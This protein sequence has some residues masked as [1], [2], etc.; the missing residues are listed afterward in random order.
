[1]KFIYFTTFFCIATLFAITNW[2]M[3][4][5]AQSIQV[6]YELN[7]DGRN[8]RSTPRTFVLPATPAVALI[9]ERKQVLRKKRNVIQRC[10]L[11]LHDLGYKI[12]DFRD[13]YDV[14]LFI[15]LLNFQSKYGL[16]RTG[17]FDA[18]TLEQ[19]RCGDK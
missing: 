14:H 15:H 16:P 19:L 18:K 6:L 8:E 17:K 12:T 4:R 11:R 3:L 9:Q 1:M 2:G 5:D 7:E 13:I 10:M